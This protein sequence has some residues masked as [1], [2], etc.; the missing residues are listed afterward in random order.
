MLYTRGVHDFPSCLYAVRSLK[1]A[2]GH[3]PAPSLA[4]AQA[5]PRLCRMYFAHMVVR[6]RR[7][8]REAG[9]EH[10]TRSEAANRDARTRF[11]P[12]MN[13]F[14]CRRGPKYFCVRR[15]TFN[16]VLLLCSFLKLDGK[17]YQAK[18]VRLIWVEVT[19]TKFLRLHFQPFGSTPTTLS[20][21]E[22]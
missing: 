7:N 12:K 18:N 5:L 10:M 16:N 22:R 21:A 11:T 1:F 19:H 8:G 13:P 2:D 9:Q 15:H 3:R 4:W 20:R 14:P 17:Q 6:N